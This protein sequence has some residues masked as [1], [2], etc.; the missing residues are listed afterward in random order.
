ATAARVHHELPA[1]ADARDGRAG[2]L[3]GLHGQAESL[4][5]ETVRARAVADEG[6]EMVQVLQ[7]QLALRGRLDGAATVAVRAAAAAIARARELH[8]EPLRVGKEQLFRLAAR[9]DPGLHRV[10]D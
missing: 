7:A 10:L 8:D 3:I 5:I 6:R 1:V 2:A 9:A 4:L